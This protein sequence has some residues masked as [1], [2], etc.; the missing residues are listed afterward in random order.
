[1]PRGLWTII[2]PPAFARFFSTRLH[3]ICVSPP[4]AA[5]IIIGVLKMA[6][7]SNCYGHPLRDFS[8]RPPEHI[9]TSITMEQST[10]ERSFASE[11]EGSPISLTRCSW[12]LG[13]Q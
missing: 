8:A 9:W 5:G 11:L 2:P 6:T 7:N 1:M 13:K 3:N 12:F 10:V 4:T